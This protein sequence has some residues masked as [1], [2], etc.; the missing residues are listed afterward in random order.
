MTPAEKLGQLAQFRW[1]GASGEG[2]RRAQYRRF[3][4]EGTVGSFLGISG[5]DHLQELQKIAVG[6]S[7]LGIPLLFAEDV[8]HGYRTIFPVP[9]AEACSWDTAAVR[10]TARIAA[11]EAAAAGIH[12][13]FAPMVDIARDPRWGRIV[14]GSGEDPFISSLMAAARVRGFQ[15]QDLS[16]P[17]TILACAKHF[18]A[19]GGAEGGRDYNTVDISLRT[20]REVYLPPF[21]AAVNAGVRTV[22]AAFNEIGGV[23]MHANSFLINEVLRSEWGFEGLVISDYTGVQELLQHGVAGTR[24]EAGRLALLAGVDVDMVSGIYQTDL[25]QKLQSGSLSTAT[26][27]TAVKRVLRAKWELGLFEDPYRYLSSSREKSF[28]LAP[29]HLREARE[30]ARKSIVLLKNEDQ[31]LPLPRT[32]KRLAVIGSLARDKRSQLGSWAASGRPED[33]VSIWE[34]IQK[35]AGPR[36]QVQYADGYS[37]QD[38]EDTT[39]T[40]EAVELAQLSDMVILVL[41]E[42]YDMTGEAASRASIKLPG[43]Q[44]ELAQ[45]I[46]ATGTPVVVLLTN[47]RPLSIPWIS[48]N[49]PAILECWYLGVQMGPAVADVL[50][51]NYNPA[52]KLAVTFPRTAGQIPI[53]YNHKNTGRPATD[54]KYTSKYLTLPS[55][56]LYPFGYGLSYSNFSFQSLRLQQNIMHPEDTLRVYVEVT[57]TGSRSGNEVVQLYIHDEVASI[58]RP[59][60]ELRGFHRI[61]L[62]PKESRRVS[63]AITANDLSFLNLN[64]EK[65][66]EP[67]FFTVFVGGNS[68]ETMQSRFEYR[69]PEKTEG[70]SAPPLRDGEDNPV[71]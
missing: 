27:D 53:Y 15:Q 58:T 65:V 11:K 70:A 25:M 34:A 19:Y 28:L 46:Q 30:M 31:T 51:G 59:V 29:E 42:T 52:G 4:S 33:A 68:Q 14:E 60:K 16:D 1:A 62:Q 3:I 36:I 41:G 54:E 35:E 20:L 13:T 18:V 57:N 71:H 66:V 5:V 55:T 6:K 64:M 45:A 69:V 17:Y 56:P 24:E 61:R 48:E 21:H 63:F 39:G 10:S 44:T 8:I 26:V 7:R 67:G 38:W 43:R 40:G 47:G 49:I 23:P 50:F 2:E 22:M 32:L 37:T 9:L 12:W